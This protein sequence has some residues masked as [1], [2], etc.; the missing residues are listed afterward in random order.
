MKIWYDAL[1][2][3]HVRY[4]AAIAARL[5]RLGCDVILTTRKHPD[6]LELA[7]TLGENF[8]PVGQYNPTS[9]YTRL[10]HSVKRILTLSKMFKDDLPV[11]AISH[12]SVELCRVAFG[13]NVPI[14]LTAD[15]PHAT[16]VNK[17]TVPLAKA[18][19]VSEAI[20]KKV[21]KE[22]GASTLLQFKGVD[23]VAWIKELKNPQKYDYK[24]PLIVV[25]QIETKA[26]YAVGKSDITEQIAKKLATI[27]NVVFLTRYRRT[28][29]K[30]LI[31][32]KHFVDS[33]SL[34]ADADLVVSAGGTIAR[35]AALQG[36]PSIVIS[37]FGQTFVNKYLSKHNFPLFIVDPSK[38]LPLA[39]KYLGTKWDVKEKLAK[40][41]N[42]IDVIEKLITE[43]H[44]LGNAENT[45]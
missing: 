3:K 16:A 7:K 36:T 1:T 29:R 2:G 27:G 39:K 20:P 44:S 19:I 30:N 11:V 35:E 38:V 9:L 10:T 14:I 15:T 12:Q 24:K 41:E 34:V 28:K 21:Y 4:G 31:I 26:A 32:P 8:I 22:Y 6:T 13:L 17:L 40:L 25:R 33:A 42:P 5:R 45:K 18:I 43:K 37:E 23:E